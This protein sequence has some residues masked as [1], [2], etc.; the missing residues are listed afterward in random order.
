[1]ALRQSTGLRNALD[2]GKSIRKVFEDAILNIYS[3]PAPSLADAAPTGSVLAKI[4]TASGAV[5]ALARSTP[6]IWKVTIGDY[7]GGYT[8]GLDIT[9]DSVKQ[10]P[11]FTNTPTLGSVILVAGALAQLVNDCAPI[12]CV[13]TG[14]DG[15]FYISGP[16]GLDF[17]VAKTSGVT[18]AVTVATQVQVASALNTLRFGPPALGVISKSGV[19]SGPV[20]I[21]GVAGYFRLVTNLD[22][23]DLDSNY[24]DARLQGDIST[25]GAEVNLS[26]INLVAGATQTIDTFALTEPAV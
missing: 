10:T 11:L 8:Y 7:T 1:M 16:A 6:S 24:S 17:T 5:T 18:G 13:P 15:V 14:G 19:W 23:A 22:G 21:T 26:N 25:S 12:I 2:G 20:L 3:G 4:T 9:V